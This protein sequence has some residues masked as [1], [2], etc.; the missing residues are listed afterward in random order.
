MGGIVRIRYHRKIPCHVDAGDKGRFYV[1]AMSRVASEGHPGV[2]MALGVF[3]KGGF[4]FNVFSI[5]AVL[6]N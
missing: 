2:V 4:E 5:S 1:I 3:F 6:G